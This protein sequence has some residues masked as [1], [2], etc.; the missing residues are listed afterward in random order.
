MGRRHH[1]HADRVRPCPYPSHLAAGVHLHEVEPGKYRTYAYV[2]CPQ[3]QRAAGQGHRLDCTQPHHMVGETAMVVI[4]G[5][6]S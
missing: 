6:G 1:K 5:G 4:T 3:C 2:R